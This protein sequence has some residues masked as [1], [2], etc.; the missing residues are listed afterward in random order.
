MRLLRITIAHSVYSKPKGYNPE[1]SEGSLD[2]V[3]HVIIAKPVWEWDD[4]SKVFLR[5]GS[6]HLGGWK[7]NIGNFVKKLV[8]EL[9]N[10]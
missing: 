8:S 6:K 7:R 1:G 10:A 2:V 3:F 9:Y 4:E 5:F